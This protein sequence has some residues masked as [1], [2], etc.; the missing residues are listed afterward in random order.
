[1][2]GQIYIIQAAIYYDSQIRTGSVYDEHP[3]MCDTMHHALKHN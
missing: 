1:M 3:R 2:A